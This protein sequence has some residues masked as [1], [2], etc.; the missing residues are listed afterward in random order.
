MFNVGCYFIFEHRFPI[1]IQNT[2]RDFSIHKK[3]T[4]S[5][6]TLSYI[7]VLFCLNQIEKFGILKN[8]NY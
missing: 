6:T 2:I 5:H 7:V 1:I 8:I 3:D 4:K